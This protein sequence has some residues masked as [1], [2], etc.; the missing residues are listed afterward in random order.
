MDETA[1][2]EPET[3][4]GRGAENPLAAE[5]PA[6]SGGSLQN[7]RAGLSEATPQAA[8][9][10]KWRTACLTVTALLVLTLVAGSV[11]AS[12]V[13]MDRHAM[14]DRLITARLAF[15]DQVDAT[16]VQMD[17]LQQQLRS[18]QAQVAA[19][20]ATIAELQRQITHLNSQIIRS[21]Q[22]D[23]TQPDMSGR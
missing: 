18:S 4:C 15:H 23:G 17:Q 6:Q 9:R 14:Q 12:L 20:Q 21:S 7:Y 11:G 10:T 5:E 13:H 1:V 19:Q 22:Q 16:A 8:P 3:L 2:I